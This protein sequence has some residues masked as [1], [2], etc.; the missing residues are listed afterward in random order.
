[1]KNNSIAAIFLAAG[2]SKRMGVNKLALP[3]GE[4]TIGSLALEKAVKAEVD[5]VFVVTSEMGDLQWIHPCLLR[6]PLKDKWTGVPCKDADKGMAHSLQCGLRAAFERK[7]FGMMVLLADQPFLSIETI[8]DLVNRFA[9]LAKE[10]MEISFMAASLQGIPRPPII[11]SRLAIPILFEL[12]GDIGARRLVQEG[13]LKGL[14]IEYENER[15]FFDFDT[16][17]EYQSL[18]GA[19]GYGG[20]GR[21]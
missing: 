13:I 20:A 10:E 3:L 17:D 6:P 9:R 15:D 8:N 19:A 7:P 1:M 11:F 14:F 18:K 12:K 5:H 4:S 2:K 21:R 16:M